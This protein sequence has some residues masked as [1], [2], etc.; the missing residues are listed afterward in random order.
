MLPRIES[1]YINIRYINQRDKLI[2]FS[3]LKLGQFKF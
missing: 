3:G 2:I 1:V